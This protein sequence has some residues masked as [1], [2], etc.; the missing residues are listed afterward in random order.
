MHSLTMLFLLWLLKGEILRYTTNH[1]RISNVQH[2]TGF[3]F[4]KSV[5]C[6]LDI[7]GTC[8]RELFPIG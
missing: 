8:E 4:S 6:G 2:E 5:T 1:L 3:W 7:E